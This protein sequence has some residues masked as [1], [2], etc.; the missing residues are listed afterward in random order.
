MPVDEP[1]PLSKLRRLVG[2][3]AREQEQVARLHHPRKAHKQKRVQRQG[4]GGVCQ[5]TVKGGSPRKEGNIPT[6]ILPLMYSGLF[7]VSAIAA[8]GSVQLTTMQEKKESN[9][10]DERESERASER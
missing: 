10:K 8:I 3:V 7:L 2:Q 6:V 5:L 9:E 4:C 1:V